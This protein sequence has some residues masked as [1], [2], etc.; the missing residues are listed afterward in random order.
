MPAVPAY[1]VI[2]R[3]N[4]T[5]E[6]Q[7]IIE[8]SGADPSKAKDVIRKLVEVDKVDAIVGGI[9]IIGQITKPYATEARIAPVGASCLAAINSRINLYP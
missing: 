1:S 2:F 8:D 6:Y 9:S 3:R 5:Y 7:L 4:T